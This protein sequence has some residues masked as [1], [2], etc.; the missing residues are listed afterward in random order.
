[1]MEERKYFKEEVRIMGI[2]VGKGVGGRG[3]G[4]RGRERERERERPVFRSF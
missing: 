4:E 2:K 3:S 1:M